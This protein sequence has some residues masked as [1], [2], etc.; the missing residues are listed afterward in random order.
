MLQEWR[1]EITQFGLRWAGHSDP[2]TG[3]SPLHRQGPSQLKHCRSPDFLP[4]EA[5]KNQRPKERCV[6]NWGKGSSCLFSRVSV[7]S[8][9]TLVC[10]KIG[11]FI[12][13]PPKTK[14]VERLE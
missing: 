8:N 6:V 9:P 4:F 11:E 1:A 3:F 5:P 13:A 10:N 7:E 12:D 2:A 14:H